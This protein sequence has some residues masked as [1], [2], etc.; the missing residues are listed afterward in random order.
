MIL[1]SYHRWIFGNN[2]LGSV[3]TM[4]YWIVQEFELQ[5]IAAETI[6]RIKNQKGK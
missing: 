6:K 5:T 3:E 1:A 4:R 2:H